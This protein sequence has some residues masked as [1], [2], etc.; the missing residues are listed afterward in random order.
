MKNLMELHATEKLYTGMIYSVKGEPWEGCNFILF[1]DKKIML[2]DE[3]CYTIK[4]NI[5]MDSIHYA[6]EV[7]FNAPDFMSALFGS[8]E[9][10]VEYFGKPLTGSRSDL[11]AELNDNLTVTTAGLINWLEQPSYASFVMKRFCAQDK[12]SLLNNGYFA[13]LDHNNSYHATIKLT[14]KE[15]QPVVILNSCFDSTKAKVEIVNMPDNYKNRYYEAF[16]NNTSDR[17]TMFIRLKSLVRM[18]F[19]LI[20][21]DRLSG[22]SDCVMSQIM[23][24]NISWAYSRI[25]SKDVTIENPKINKF[26][27]AEVQVRQS[28]IT[29][30]DDIYYDRIRNVNV[31]TYYKYSDPGK[32]PIARQMGKN[33][34][35]VPYIDAIVGMTGYS[36]NEYVSP[37]KSNK[38]NVSWN[39]TNVKIPGSYNKRSKR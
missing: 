33:Y 7:G 24:M 3:E 35:V 8:D 15:I 25:I 2:F 34:E 37:Y 14:P 28:L 19:T 4:D 39:K 22:Y 13:Y 23:G 5:Y 1:T 12:L 38:E 32:Q 36:Y 31:D 26:T 9:E 18:D 27:G 30:I 21:I 29:P 20:A 11:I 6:R 16:N 17:L 10:A